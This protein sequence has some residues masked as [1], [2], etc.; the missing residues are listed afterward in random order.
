[1]RATREWVGGRSLAAIYYCARS[2]YHITFQRYPFSYHNL[3]WPC[4][5]HLLIFFI[6]IYLLSRPLDLNPHK[7]CVP[8]LPFLCYN[9]PS[10]RDQSVGQH[11]TLLTP[12]TWLV[13]PTTI[14]LVILSDTGYREQERVFFF[15]V[16]HGSGRL[17][18]A[19]SAHSG[20]GT[21]NCP[22]LGS[23]WSYSFPFLFLG[24]W[25]YCLIWMCIMPRMI[26]G[27]GRCTC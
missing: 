20:A 10:I 25:W 11:V 2:L 12:C 14:S 4:R 18:M 24:I 23:L 8:L 16:W 27:I 15:F 21:V 7:I 3:Y 22:T 6:I 1:M 5:S 17:S 13:Q 26:L 19:W 9:T